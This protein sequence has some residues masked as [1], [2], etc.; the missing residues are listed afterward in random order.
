MGFL[1]K[2]SKESYFM[3]K[4]KKNNTQIDG[5]QMF[6]FL[7]YF[8]SYVLHIHFF[9]FRYAI[10]HKKIFLQLTKRNMLKAKKFAD[11]FL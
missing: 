10:L 6:F 2:T 5:F 1:L 11:I 8:F 3:F 7:L 9:F 4:N